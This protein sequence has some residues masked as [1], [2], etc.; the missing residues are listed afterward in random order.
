[1]I[2]LPTFTLIHVALSVL[3]ILSGLAVTGGLIAGASLGGWTALFLV[4]TAL[5]SATGFGFPSAELSAAHTAGALSLVLL[6]VC[7][8]ARYA[9]RLAGRG[10]ATYVVTAVAALY[11]NCFV[12]VTQLFAKTPPLAQLAPTQQELPFVATQLAL[13]GLFVALAAAALRGFR[14]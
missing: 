14:R 11:L 9:L 4:S 1:M 7:G 2:D 13:L 12:L 8:V 5:T 3:G 6:A 10:R